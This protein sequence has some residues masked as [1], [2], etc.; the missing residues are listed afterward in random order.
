MAGFFKKRRG[1]SGPNKNEKKVRR[2]H[3]A[4]NAD[5]AA[6]LV[7]V[8]YPGIERLSVQLVF[9]DSRQNVL[10]Q[11]T[12]TFDSRDACNFSVNCPG[13]C[14][15]GSFDLAAKIDLVV[16][17][18]ETLS[19]SSGKCQKPLYLGSPEACGCELKCKL[20]ISY[21]PE[22]AKEGAAGEEG[23]SHGELQKD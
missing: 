5:R 12:R 22:E 13:R 4:A 7:G 20:E 11:E 2:A 8:R 19:E 1:R 14:G 18:K 21:F 3:E 16:A 15:V 17:A 10:A 23:A 6:G 9:L